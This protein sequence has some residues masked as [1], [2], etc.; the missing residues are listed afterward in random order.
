[1]SR[2]IVHFHI[3]YHDQVD[4]F[5]NKMKN[6]NG[7]DWDL[8]VTYSTASSKTEAMIKE[9][10]PDAQFL[11]VEN[12]GYD[13][14]PFIKVLKVLDFTKYDYILKLHTKNIIHEFMTNPPRRF[15][16]I[17]SANSSP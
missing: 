5:I 8:L 15:K 12:A 7:C 10:K 14:W 17:K 4:Y 13:V 3:Y 11:K 9:F 1:M 16:S 2:L 6:I